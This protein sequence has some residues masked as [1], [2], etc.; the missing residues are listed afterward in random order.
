ALV[1]AVLQIVPARALPPETMESVVSVL[2]KWPGRGQGGEGA[3]A[4]SVPEGSGVVVSRGS[5]GN[6]LIATA[7]HVI[8]PAERIDVRLADGRILP[9]ELAG[10]N[11]ETDIALLRVKAQLPAFERAPRQQVAAPVC[12]IANAYGLGLSVSCGVVSA[13]DVSN[14]G[15][16]PVEDFV[17]T[18]AAANPGS[19]GGALVD[20]Q[21]RLVGM[22]SAI[23]AAEADTNIG[24]NFAISAPLLNRVV[25]DL[26]DDGAVD[27]VSAG[28]RLERLSRA[29]RAE[30][31]GVR[32][33]QVEEDGPA[34]ASGIESGD[35]V[36]RIGPRRVQD[37]KDVVG[38]LALVAPGGA[39]DVTVLRGAEERRIGLSFGPREAN[40]ETEEEAAASGDPD[41]EHPEPVCD[42]RQAVFPVESFDPLASA[43][44]IAPDLLV[45]NRH[46][47]GDKAE[48]VVHT[49]S[50][51]R[52]G[53]VIA[54]AYRG[55]LALLR[56][57][58][59]PEDGLVLA[60]DA[61]MD[62]DIGAGPFYAVGA[63]LGE[64]EI[65]VFAPG[66]LTLPPAEGA[67]LGRL[68]VTSAIQP[69]VSGGALVDEHGRLVGIA[70]GGGE[71][72]N[73]A[74]PVRE[75][76]ELLALRDADNAQAVH[77][78]LGRALV[79]CA[80][81]LDRAEGSRRLAEDVTESI[82]EH[83]RASENAGQYQRAGRLLGTAG[84]IPASIDFNK[85]AV[86][87]V[88]NSINARMSLLVSLQLAGRFEQMLPHARWLMK[89]LPEEPQALR[90]AIQSGV[91]GGDTALAE[92]AYDKLEAVDPRQAQAARRFIDNAPPAPQ[93]R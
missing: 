88:P 6:A 68:H 30:T 79:R 85:A 90:F 69:G 76:G 44:R 92:K 48:A 84:N 5:E 81:A 31:S 10:H 63:D 23:F 33:A 51:Q 34:A 61:A 47:V 49:P 22:I 35:I 15:F 55:D 57:D 25:D 73:E 28:W 2:P 43:V 89:A 1:A 42:A 65:R 50:G 24:V 52:K 71:G 83:C 53:E 64:K 66:K 29:E 41:C 87:Q 12:T 74:L 72:R 4:G 36:T 20:G 91:W 54:S 93:S 58:G 75:V 60:P 82:V 17:Q 3:P 56:V 21:G 26:R 45:T 62:A 78:D 80:Q 7:W 40:A 8:E 18:D 77:E 11:A 19:S 86:E 46:T 27:W 37:P 9:A 39:V 70:T 14:A 16:N 59:L 32:V 67:P 38:A 13:L